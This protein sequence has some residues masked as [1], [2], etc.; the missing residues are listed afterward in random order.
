MPERPHAQAKV[1]PDPSRP[2][3][4]LVV[5]VLVLWM[6]VIGARLVHLQ[7]GQTETLSARAHRQQQQTIETTAPRGLILDRAGRE[8][9]RTL[10]VDSFFIVPDELTDVRDA[11]ARLAPVLDLKPM[12]LAARV[13]AARDAKRKFVWVA[14][15]VDAAQAERVRALQ[16]AGVHVQKETKRYYPNGV[17]AAHV[18][19]FVGTDDAGLAGIERMQNAALAGAAGQVAL[20]DD[21]RRQAYD[22]RTQEAQTGR[23]LVLTIDQN[24]QYQA[25]QALAAAVAQAHAKSGTAIVLDP[26]TG[27]ILALANVP[28]FDPNTLSY[29]VNVPFSCQ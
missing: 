10:E 8:L 3:T 18:L 1:H 29:T 13:Q 23:S 7:V 6:L 27:E 2:R 20:D 5:L 26:R 25:E 12:E 4:S 15:Q 24:V 16:L 17:L 28:T 11:A 19:G 22:S 14:R 21:G 9:A